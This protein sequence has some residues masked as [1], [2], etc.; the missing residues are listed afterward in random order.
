MKTQPVPDY[1]PSAAAAVA[2][3]RKRV[4]D[5]W[6][7]LRR[8]RL[9][10]CGAA[11]LAFF[12]V[13]ALLAPWLA[14]YSPT[15]QNLPASLQPPGPAHLL[16]TDEFG[17]DILSRIIF[18]ARFSLPVGFFS[19]A[20]ALA[21]GGLLGMLAGYYGGRLDNLIM[22]VM[23]V[24]LALPT[25]LL[26]IV[27]VTALGPGLTNVMVAVGISLIPNFA[28]VAKAA[29]L[30]VRELEY[31]E[32]AR[33]SGAGTLRVIFR[34]ILPNSLA[35]II[36]QG[37]LSV[38]GAILSA[39]ALS[40][41]GLGA[42]PPTPEWGSMLSSGRAFLRDAPH[43]TTFPGLAILLTVLALNLFGDGLRDALDPRLRQFNR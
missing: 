22:R 20:I 6:W 43:V 12:T 4:S 36:V 27:I 37:T 2:E 34:H 26:A 11:V 33:A 35:P 29:V 18:G 16:G 30:G 17:R 25:I 42:Q 9:A 1:C 19:V 8:N 13:V 41:I 21:G 31:V 3:H 40:F 10:L 7:Q 14:P 39:A 24:M 38:A 5:F 15:A 23:D 28:R 32:A